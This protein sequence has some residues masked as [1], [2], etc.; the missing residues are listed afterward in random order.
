LCQLVDLGLN[1]LVFTL[2]NGYISD[3]AKRNIRQIVDRLGLELVSGSTP[4]M[5]EIFADSLKRYSN[6][7]EGCFKTIYTLST[8]LALERGISYIVT[9]LSR[10][11]IFETRI[12]D[13]FHQRVFD[14]EQIDKTVIE[15]RKAYHRM[16][17]AVSRNIDCGVFRDDEVFQK[18]RYLDFYRYCD[19]ELDEVL[20]YLKN[21]IGWVRPKDT[22]RSTNCLINDVGIY[23][24]KK[25][26][27]YHNYAEPYSW[28]VRLGHKRRDAARDELNDRIN[29]DNVHRILKEIGY[30]PEEPLQQSGRQHLVA[31]YVAGREIPDDE[32][33]SHIASLLPGEFVPWQFVRIE[34]LPLTHNGKVDRR[35]LPEPG[36]ERPGGVGEYVEPEGSVEKQLARLWSEILGVDRIGVNDS[37]FDLGGDSI[38]NIQIVAR[39]KQQGLAITPQNIFDH[40]TIGE[41]AAVARQQTAGTAEQGPVTGPVPLTPIQQRFFEQAAHQDPERLSQAVLLSASGEL[42]ADRLELAWQEVMKHHDALR[43]RF[44]RAGDEW[45]QAIAAPDPGLLEFSRHDLGGSDAAEL[46]E[47]I[48]AIA[49]DLNRR[50]NLSQGRLV[51]VALLDHGSVRPPQMLAAIH[52]L[53]VDAVSWWVL[54]QD[55]ET[56]YGQ[57]NSGRGIVLPAKTSSIRE[58]AAELA[59]YA[60]SPQVEASIGFWADSDGAA[61]MPLDFADGS[62]DRGSARTVS[63]E[64]DRASTSRL[65][66][67]VPAAFRVQVPE[68]LLAAI[69]RSARWAPDAPIR[70]DLEGHGR[71]EIAPDLDLLRTVGWFT[72]IYPVELSGDSGSAPEQVLAEVKE[73]LRAVPARGLDYGVL[74]YM[75]PDEML[76]TRLGRQRPADILFNY[77]GQ[78]DQT[79]ASS[80]RFAFERPI[81]ALRDSDAMREHVLEVNAM[82]FDGVLRIDITYSENLHSSTTIERLAG[83]IHNEVRK[84]IDASVDHE[85]SVL[86]PSD[87]P[88]AG[89]DQD[90][91]NNILDEFGEQG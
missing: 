12:A 40:P 68:V 65:I 56:A 84:L 79:L 71:E 19:V 29:V 24:H 38:L 63:I 6:V 20:D 54:L 80:D 43:A 41:L 55:L 37:F 57:L 90:E 15:A 36:L 3:G 44:T 27:G 69:R 17:D 1:P 4:A 78:W 75:H 62:N 87:F 32:L 51:Q 5:N 85:R 64:L 52:H 22:G 11:Q 74:R 91:L 39:A 10:G 25:E 88:S 35:A 45:R 8:K 28:D 48:D 58:W 76:R 49:A 59:S 46:D 31:W 9:G 33:R 82:V 47:T 67:E 53:V 21:R 60:H 34:R 14:P 72:S 89:L 7:C 42:D 61:P 18:V 50:I 13:L 16:E 81:M 66:H 86:T 2:D 23:V 30:R 73:Q 26:R 83:D 70:V 77:L